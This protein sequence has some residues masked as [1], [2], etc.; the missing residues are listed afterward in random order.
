MNESTQT[1]KRHRRVT[2]WELHA[3]IDERQVVIA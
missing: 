2:V 3:K 1:R